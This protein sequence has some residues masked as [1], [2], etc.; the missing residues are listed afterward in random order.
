MRSKRKITFLILIII[1][2]TLIIFLGEF[3]YRTSLQKKDLFI[4]GMSQANLYEPWRV[5]MNKE[6]EEE[7]KKHKNIKVI[8]RDADGDVQR[9]KKD[10]DD[11]IDF[12][13]DLLIVSTNDSKELEETVKKAYQSIPVIMLDRS[14]SQSDYTLYIGTDVKSIGVQAGLLAKDLTG[15]KKCNVVEVQGVLN[16]SVDN[17]I[18]KGFKDSI[19]KYKNIN[20]DRTIVGNWQKNETQ[21]KLESILKDDKDINMIFAHSDYMSIGAYYAKLNTKSKDVKIIGV[22]GLEG[23][24]GG[25]E[26][27]EKGILDGT[28]TCKTGGKEAVEYAIRILNKEK[29][30]PK[31]VLFDSKKITRETL[32][33]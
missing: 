2:L 11:L 32:E 23:S 20:I 31:K 16:S 13:A 30:L 28:F 29:D 10:I 19:S 27:V 3:I 15:D 17:E 7:V 6:I 24:E 4:I 9:Q 1:I 14:V 8:F 25:I 5:C 22:D 33:N 12:G 18:T 21:D 26:L